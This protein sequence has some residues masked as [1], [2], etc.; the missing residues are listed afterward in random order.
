MVLLAALLVPLFVPRAALALDS[1]PWDE[2]LRAHA[3]NGRMDYGALKADPGAMAKLDRFLGSVAEMP[4]SEGLASWLNA[5]NALVVKAVVE[6]YPL[7]SVREVEG[8]FDRARHPV[9]GRQRTLDAIENQIIRRRFRDARIHFAL[10]CAARSCPALHGRAF[11]RS[12]L[13]ATLD[14]LVRRAL[15]SP[16][17]VRVV[18]GQLRV[19]EIFHWFAEDFA[20]EK[21]S[22][23][24]WIAAH[25][26]E[27]GGADESA[28]VGRIPYDWGLNDAR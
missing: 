25:G 11:A 26:G 10:N 14:R 9:A 15:R 8:F 3:R 17:H 19:S 28:N 13:D 24:A 22:L 2:V 18:D 21:G 23:L 16:R 27:T 5:Y 7:D 1:A 20:R 4:V 12:S 6:R